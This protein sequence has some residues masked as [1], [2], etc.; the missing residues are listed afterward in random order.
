MDIPVLDLPDID[1]VART[2]AAALD[3]APHPLHAVIDGALFDD[4]PGDLLRAGFSCRSLFLEHGDEEVERAGPWLLALDSERA[5]AHAEALAIAQPCAVFWSCPEGEMALWRHLRTI[6]E[7]MIPVESETLEGAPP[8]NPV[9]ERVMFRHWDPNVLASVMPL[10]DAA[11]FARMFGPASHIVINGPDTGGLKRIPR[12]QNLPSPP[13]GPL[14]LSPEQMEGL[15]A[16][17]VH[18]SRLRIARYLKGN[19]P[20]HFSGVDDAFLWG[21]ALASETAA[22]GLGIETERGRARW[23]YIMM[24]SDGRAADVKEVRGFIQN[25]P[26]S[27]DAQV[28][29]LM[30]HTAA[31]L[32][33]GSAG[34]K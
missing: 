34:V 33:D 2:L 32:R 22:D 6:N 20:A 4:L 28:S 13:H 10:L 18:S 25:G 14:L 24:L 5:R 8:E 27:P 17:M 31:A 1:A 7:A 11:Q 29:A 30:K 15:K 9:F 12:P 23:A 16:A 26:E 19:V 21:T 3:S